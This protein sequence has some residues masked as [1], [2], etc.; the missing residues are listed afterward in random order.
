ML[1]RSD[2]EEEGPRY[3]DSRKHRD[4]YADAE[5]QSEAFDS[6][7]AEP[8]E[9]DCGNDT[10]DV[11]VTD[12]EPGPVETFMQSIVNRLAFLQFFLG[13][14]KDKHIGIHRHADGEDKPGD[15]GRRESDRDKLENR[16]TED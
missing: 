9:H 6:R 7:G 12:G 8:E 16:Q 5:S 4:H 3:G 14:L 1:F 11:G 15:A 2:G 10:R 13:A